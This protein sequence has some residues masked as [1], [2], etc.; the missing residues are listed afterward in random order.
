MLKTPSDGVAGV[1]LHRVSIPHRYAENLHTEPPPL[2]FVL[3][4]SL[5]GM[6][7]TKMIKLEKE[8]KQKF[9]SL[10]GMLKTVAEASG[11]CEEGRFNPS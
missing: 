11:F 7:K 9:Q 6:L 2:D 10:I 8:Q 5:I 1:L 4:Q 3:F